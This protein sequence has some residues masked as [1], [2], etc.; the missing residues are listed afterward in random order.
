M[1]ESGKTQE[2]TVPD[3][4][5]RDEAFSVDLEFTLTYLALTGE[6]KTLPRVFNVSMAMNNTPRQVL[7][8]ISGVWRVRCPRCRIAGDAGD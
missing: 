7:E 8:Q 1:V 4:T 6:G 5:Y 2:I 3:S